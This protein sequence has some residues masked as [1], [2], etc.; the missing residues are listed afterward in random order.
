[1]HNSNND[2]PKQQIIQ[3]LNAVPQRMNRF[4][5]PNDDDGYETYDDNVTNPNETMVNDADDINLLH[6]IQKLEL[7][8]KNVSLKNN[9]L[10]R[11]NTLNENINKGLKRQRELQNEIAVKEKEKQ[12]LLS[13]IIIHKQNEYIVK[14]SS[15]RNYDILNF[16]QFQSKQRCSVIYI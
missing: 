12:A 8:N 14:Y 2:Q 13:G 3:K 10:V 7:E 1:M 6:D 9:L 15:I 11:K 4:Q 16:F 5:Y